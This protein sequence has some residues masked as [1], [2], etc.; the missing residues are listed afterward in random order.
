MPPGPGNPVINDPFTVAPEVV[1]SPIRPPEL[2]PSDTNNSCSLR[3]VAGTAKIA[4]A[5]ESIAAT[6]RPVAGT[7]LKANPNMRPSSQRNRSPSPSAPREFA[8]LKLVEG[9]HRAPGHEEIR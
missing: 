1:Y 2:C 8:W 4:A 3:P 7:V 5:P 9:A 6:H